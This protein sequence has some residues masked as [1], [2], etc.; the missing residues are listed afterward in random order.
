LDGIGN[1]VDNDDD[2]DQI[3]DLWETRYGLNPTDASDALLDHDNDGLNALKEY[4]A[5]TIPLEILDIDVD[6][7]FIWFY[8]DP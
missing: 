4:E 5:G 2:N 8:G 7:R 6:G 1:N 3:P